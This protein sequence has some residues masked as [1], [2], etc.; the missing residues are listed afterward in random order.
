[1]EKKCEYTR[2]YDHRT[3]AWCYCDQFINTGSIA[4][5]TCQYISLFGRED[6]VKAVAAG[7]LGNDRLHIEIG[8]EDV[9]RDVGNYRVYTRK[10]ENALHKIVYNASMFGTKQNNQVILG[11][12]IGELQDELFKAMD[13]TLTTPLSPRWAARLF[14]WMFDDEAGA[15][16]AR[17]F[18]FGGKE[19][20]EVNIPQE[21]TVEEFILKYLLDVAV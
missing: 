19:A 18:G 6:S 9:Q 1:M 7:F 12:N 10:T 16:Y 4:Y 21:F 11:E 15:A 3:G 2:V 5:G 20:L 17:I 14:E 13:R 8:S